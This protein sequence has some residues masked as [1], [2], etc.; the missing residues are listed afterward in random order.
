[1]ALVGVNNEPLL[2]RAVFGFDGTNYRVVKVDTDGNL[3]A[4]LKASQTIE[5]TQDTAA[6]LKATVNIAASQE[7]EVTQATAADLK[8]TVTIPTDQDIEARSFGWFG[9]A[10]QKNSLLLGYRDNLDEDLA[11]TATGTSTTID[12][13][14]VPANTV[15]IIQAASIFNE[16]RNMT[17]CVINLFKNSGAVVRLS[18]VASVTQYYPLLIPAPVVLSP[19]D[20]IRFGLNG[21]VNLDSIK[22]G[23]SG[24]QFKTNL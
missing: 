4:A 1:M 10:W 16:T 22:G 12:T 20:Y 18:Y 14:A 17:I 7:I 13:T 11:T 8:A 21:T 15:H 23:V 6:D 9:S 2:E 24:Y 3:V 19:G 5:V